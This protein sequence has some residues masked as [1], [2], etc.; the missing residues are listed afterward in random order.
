MTV[1]FLALVFVLALALSYGLAW[2]FKDRPAEVWREVDRPVSTQTPTPPQTLPSAPPEWPACEPMPLPQRFAG[3]SSRMGPLQRDAVSGQIALRVPGAPVAEGPRLTVV[4]S[5]SA[6]TTTEFAREVDAEPDGTPT[7]SL[8][9]VR[10]D[11]PI[12]RDRLVFITTACL[13]NRAARGDWWTHDPPTPSPVP[14]T[15]A[16]EV[17]VFVHL[18]AKLAS[19]S[20]AF[21]AH[22]GLMP[23]DLG[24]LAVAIPGCPRIAV[25]NSE[26]DPEADQYATAVL[27]VD[28]AGEVLQAPRP[29][30]IGAPLV[31]LGVIDLDGDGIDELLVTIRTLDQ[32]HHDELLWFDSTTSQWQTH[33][34]APP[35]PAP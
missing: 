30:V 29:P 14:M 3:Q 26:V 24:M 27:C 4:R 19:R 20:P 31:Q 17:S 21:A 12:V 9:T 15:L 35:R 16:A 10:I 33:V 7:L 8:L 32:Q 34:L 2:V 18:R 5:R 25:V 23:A 11:P 28:A 22:T 1:R 13:P 6:T